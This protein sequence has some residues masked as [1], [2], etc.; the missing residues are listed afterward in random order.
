MTNEFLAFIT[1]LLVGGFIGVFIMCLVIA[2]ADS[3]DRIE[4]ANKNE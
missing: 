2:S 4:E 3:K 1:G